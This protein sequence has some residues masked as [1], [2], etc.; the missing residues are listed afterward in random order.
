M[1]RHLLPF[2]FCL[3]AALPAGAR[4]RTDTIE[5]DES[6]LWE[7]PRSARVLA[8]ELAFS[9]DNFDFP[10]NDSIFFL[11]RFNDGWI[12]MLSVFRIK[13]FL[14][15]RWGIYA[16]VSEPDGTSHWAK[17]EMKHREVV[18]DTERLFITDGRNTIEGGPETCRVRCDIDG[19]SCD[20]VFENLLPPWKPGDGT[21]YYTPDRRTFQFRAIS[22]PWANV[23][24]ELTAG[25]KTVSVTGDGFGE[26]A[27]IICPFSKFNPYTYSLRLYSDPA[28]KQEE[29]WHIEMLESIM[30]DDHGGRRIPRLIVA[31]G[32]DW[33]LTTRQYTLTPSDSVIE[34][35]LP[36]GYPRRLKLT[37]EADGY[38]LEGVYKARKLFNYTD[39]LDEIP[40]EFR[41]LVAALM[42]RPVY[43]R[44][45][46][47]FEGRLTLPD[48]SVQELRLFGPYEYVVAK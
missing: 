9:D 39:V 3:I 4:G 5:K 40:P 22:S 45:L 35:D 33:L 24:G 10:K 23:E 12:M 7:N 25:G 44:C 18:Y 8:R 41:S 1:S 19:F 38:S 34:G 17:Y 20:L 6:E 42:K 46:G 21:E 31:K 15:D 26:K 37:F 2:V 32:G 48:G 28:L 29:R 30:H 13:A 16:V 11:S 27:L 43:F 14:V 47:A 36:F